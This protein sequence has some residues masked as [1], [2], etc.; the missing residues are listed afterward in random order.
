[1]ASQPTRGARKAQGKQVKGRTKGRGNLSAK[2]T[3]KSAKLNTTTASTK[4]AKRR[5]GAGSTS[6]SLM[7]ADV[8]AHYARALV[9][10]SADR[11]ESAKGG[12]KSRESV[13][14]RKA[15]Q[16]A[17]PSPT[18]STSE[19]EEPPVGSGPFG[20]SAVHT[21][22][23]HDE[24]RGQKR[25]G[26]A[27]DRAAGQAV[28]VPVRRRR[29]PV[30]T[31]VFS[32]PSASLLRQTAVEKK[33]KRMFMSSE[34]G[35]V[36]TVVLAPEETDE[37]GGGGGGKEDNDAEDATNDLNIKLA[38]QELLR[39]SAGQMESNAKRR[40][41][42]GRL[43]QL[44]ARGPKKQKMPMEIRHGMQK[45]SKEREQKQ[46]A[47]AVERG[48]PVKRAKTNDRPVHKRSV[49]GGHWVDKSSIEDK[50]FSKGVLR[51]GG[52]F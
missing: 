41:E 45:K 50:R 46:A 27:A 51:I 39:L 29:G 47:R 42:A 37:G 48:M 3:S 14:A 16:L 52:G 35:K 44:G 8:L 38:T 9:G 49:K 17:P 40:W 30:E 26:G 12:G 7:S 43:Q 5:D 28:V 1:M 21:H 19:E 4:K 11:G 15:K 24:P 2:S 32:D 20:M 6:D 10:K 13:K 22:P 31:V 34:V 36:H 23:S 18:N 25:G 33:G